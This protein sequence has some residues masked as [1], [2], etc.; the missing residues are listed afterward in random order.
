MYP[1][2][3]FIE[4]F[5]A[6][7]SVLIGPCCPALLKS[8]WCKCTY[9]AYYWAN[10]MMMMMMMFLSCRICHELIHRNSR[11]VQI[12]CIDYPLQAR[13]LLILESQEVKDRFLTLLSFNF[14]NYYFMVMYV[15][16]RSLSANSHTYCYFGIPSPTHSFFPGLKPSFSVNPSHC[17][18]SFL[19]T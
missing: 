1:V 16:I 15:C 9:W 3:V 12:C 5:R 11:Q 10:K 8:H 4:R 2:T 19:S 6:A 13:R 7:V 17:S 18:P 14:F